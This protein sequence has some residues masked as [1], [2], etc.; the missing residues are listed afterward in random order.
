MREITDTQPWYRQFWP[1]FVIAI[2]AMGVIG[3]IGTVI[4]ASQSPDGVVVDDYY[5]RGLAINQDLARD[6]K[7]AELG[8]VAQARIPEPGRMQV[9]L[10][11]TGADLLPAITVRLLHPT[12][13]GRDHTLLL[14]RTGSGLFEAD[15]G[16]LEP[17]HWH[18]VI[19]PPAGDWRLQDRLQWPQASAVTIRASN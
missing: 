9:S 3:G 14:H 10:T 11:G 4:I 12:K 15:L 17:A 6:R 16:A 13:A 7:A 2:P 1:W 8:L 19:E 5:K 18:V